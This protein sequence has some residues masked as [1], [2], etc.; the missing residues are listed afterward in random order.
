MNRPI[1]NILKIRRRFCL[2][3]QKCTAVC[4]WTGTEGLRI[5]NGA[6]VLLLCLEFKVYMDGDSN[7]RWVIHEAGGCFRGKILSSPLNIFSP[8]FT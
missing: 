7:R 4:R 5:E 3:D 1:L 8:C 6:T 2:K